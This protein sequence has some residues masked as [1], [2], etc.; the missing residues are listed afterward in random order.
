[1][2][3]P[4]NQRNKSGKLDPSTFESLMAGTMIYEASTEPCLPYGGYALM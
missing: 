3:F 2:Y 4:L 1:M